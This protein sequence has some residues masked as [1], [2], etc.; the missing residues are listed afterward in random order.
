VNRYYLLSYC[1]PARA[2][3]RHV[4]IKV[5]SHDDEGK[6]VSGSLSTEFD[7]SGFAS[8]CD[9]SAVPRFVMQKSA[10]VAAHNDDDKGKDK[11][12]DKD[13]DKPKAKPAKTATHAPAQKQSTDD[14]EG[15]VVPPPAKAG[16]AQ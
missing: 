6:D 13:D 16:Y 2:G 15:D 4:R 5:L 10:E 9:P 1:S 11:D 8:G 3:Q 12:K 7:A 14:E